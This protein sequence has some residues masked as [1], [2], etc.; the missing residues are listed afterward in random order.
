VCVV[1]SL[2]EKPDGKRCLRRPRRTFEDNIKRIL[3]EI[4][5]EMKWIAVIWFRIFYFKVK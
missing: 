3:N 1:E 4:G 5:R 2:V